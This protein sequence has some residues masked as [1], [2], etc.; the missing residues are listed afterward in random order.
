MNAFDNIL[1][2]NYLGGSL[3]SFYFMIPWFAVAFSP[4]P[5]A[6]LQ[7][8]QRK[9][10][11]HTSSESSR[12]LPCKGKTS[13]F[14]HCSC[15]ILMRRLASLVHVITSVYPGKGLFLPDSP[16]ILRSDLDMDNNGIYFTFNEIPHHLDLQL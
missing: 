12:T 13:P 10:E 3:A 6:P 15:L 8:L 4:L 5:P 2:N 14:S 7:S 16:D 11:P 1:N 9:A